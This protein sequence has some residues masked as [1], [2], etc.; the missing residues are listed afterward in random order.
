[1][2]YISRDISG[3]CLALCVLLAS[4]ASADDFRKGIDAF[5]NED[6]V[7]ALAEWQPLAERGDLNAMYNVGLIYDE[8]LGVEVDKEKA[9]EWYC[10]DDLRFRLWRSRG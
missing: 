2:H 7:T 1:M 10:R 8:G 5:N 6:Y 9:L 4:G 3:Y